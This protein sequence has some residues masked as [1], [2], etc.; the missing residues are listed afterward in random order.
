MKGGFFS[1][2]EIVC[3]LSFIVNVFEDFLF[4]G[5]GR[6]RSYTVMAR[7]VFFFVYIGDRWGFII[8]FFVR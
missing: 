7:I 4:F 8:G 1:W 5:G 3:Y 6:S 2:S